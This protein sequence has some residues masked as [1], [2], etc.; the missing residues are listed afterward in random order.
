MNYLEESGIP[1][2]QRASQI[3]CSLVKCS[4]VIRETKKHFAHCSNEEW[5]SGRYE[6]CRTVAEIPPC[7][8]MFTA[9]SW[10][11]AD[12]VMN[13]SEWFAH[14]LLELLI[15]EIDIIYT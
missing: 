10:D 12:I 1:A 6:H 5:L 13:R 15:K 7:G 11:L 2:L 9:I 4:F 8:K 3:A 14:F